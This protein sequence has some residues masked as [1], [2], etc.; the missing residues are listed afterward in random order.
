MSFVGILGI[1]GQGDDLGVG[2]S[3]PEILHHGIQGR[4]IANVAK[5]CVL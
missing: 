2:P 1:H 4:I 3:T 5:A